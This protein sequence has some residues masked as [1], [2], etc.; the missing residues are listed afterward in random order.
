MPIRH[1]RTAWP[2]GSPSVTSRAWER[3]RTTSDRRMGPAAMSR[4]VTHHPGSPQTSTCLAAVGRTGQHPPVADLEPLPLTVAGRR[5]EAAGLRGDPSRRPFVL[6]HEG[7]GSV[8]L[9]RGFPRALHA[10]TGRRVIAFSRFGHGRSDPPPLPRT[11]AFFHE[12]AL[13]VLPEVLAQLDAPG[14]LLVGHSD[15]GS[16]ALIHAARH[17]VPGIALLAP[18]EIAADVTVA[19]IPGGREGYDS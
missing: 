6:L 16:I 18:H 5:L 1:V 15:G 17:R 9:W 14:A 13:E 12:E 7:L 4:S 10:A 11:P 8:A 3:P 19:V 2:G